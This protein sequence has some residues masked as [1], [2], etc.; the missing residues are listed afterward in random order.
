MM[1]VRWLVFAFLYALSFFAVLAPAPPKPILPLLEEMISLLERGGA[2]EQIHRLARAI[3]GETHGGPVE[4]LELSYL[5]GGS[6]FERNLHSWASKKLFSRFVPQPYKFKLNKKGYDE[7]QDH[8]C[9]LPHELFSSLYSCDARELFHALF[10]GGDE[11]LQA[12]WDRASEVDDSWY[13]QHPVIRSQPDPL[14]RVPVGIHGDDAGMRGSESILVVTW[15]SVVKKGPTLDTRLLFSMLKQREIE[16]DVTMDQ[17]YNVLR[18]S[19]E[20]LA[21]GKFPTR[22]HNGI[23]FSE[24]YDIRRFRQRDKWLAGGYVGAWAEMRGDWKW[25][26]ETLHLQNHYGANYLCH[27]CR[28][29]RHITRLLFTNFDSDAAY[30]RT[31]VTSEDWWWYYANAILVC[32]LIMI[33]GFNIFHVLI[34]ALHSLEL[35]LHQHMSASIMW[36]LTDEPG[37]LVGASRQERFDDAY[38]KYKDWCVGG[39]VLV[40]SVCVLVAGGCSQALCFALSFT[41]C[42]VSCFKRRCVPFC[43]HPE[44]TDN[45]DHTETHAAQ[46]T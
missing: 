25:L 13:Q 15:G 35:G 27:L 23:P 10:T 6:M 3:A 7:P 28:A 29:H 36:Q 11:N 8:Y 20:H 39:S 12:W 4:V 5:G 45:T 22:D 44:T 41:L 43:M 17:F 14:R 2:C 46:Q 19:F 40:G 42:L 21:S 31:T 30:T 32:P 1:T 26:R 38:K 37:Y 16:K 18:W 34:D 24:D 33:P 9:I